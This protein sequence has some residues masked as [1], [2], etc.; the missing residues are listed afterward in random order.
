MEPTGQTQTLITQQSQSHPQGHVKDESIQQLQ[1]DTKI[2]GQKQVKH[3]IE[4]LKLILNTT[5]TQT[6]QV[7]LGREENNTIKVQ[8]QNEPQITVDMK[9]I[10]GQ[11]NAGTCS[12]KQHRIKAK[13]KK[14]NN[15]VKLSMSENKALSVQ[16]E[17]QPEKVADFS[18]TELNGQLAVKKLSDI[19]QSHLNQSAAIVEELVQTDSQNQLSGC[20]IKNYRKQAKVKREEKNWPDLVKTVK[21]DLTSHQEDKDFNEAT[22]ARIDETQHGFKTL[23]EGSEPLGVT[24]TPDNTTA[25]SKF[26]VESKIFGKAKVTSV[27]QNQVA[28]VP[29]V[30]TIVQT[31]G[32]AKEATS[33]FSPKSKQT[34]LAKAKSKISKA[35]RMPLEKSSPTALQKEEK[36]KNSEAKSEVKLLQN[37]TSIMETPA[38]QIENVAIISEKMKLPKSANINLDNQTKETAGKSQT[39]VLDSEKDS[40]VVPAA[41]EINPPQMIAG[42]ISLMETGTETCVALNTVKPNKEV[43]TKENIP[44]LCQ[45]VDATS[46]ASFDQQDSEEKLIG[47]AVDGIHL[48]FKEH[49]AHAQDISTVIENQKLIEDVPPVSKCVPEKIQ[50]E[51]IT[52]NRETEVCTE[53]KEKEPVRDVVRIQSIANDSQT[54]TTSEQCHEGNQIILRSKAIRTPETERRTFKPLE[55]ES[56]IVLEKEGHNNNP[57]IIDKCPAQMVPLE[58]ELTG[59]HEV[60]S[61][62]SL[63]QTKVKYC[64]ALGEI[65]QKINTAF[66][67]NYMKA[68]EASLTYGAFASP[69]NK[70]RATTKILEK[71]LNH[72]YRDEQMK[73]E[74]MLGATVMGGE[75]ESEPSIVT[76]AKAIS[77][78]SLSCEET[79]ALIDTEDFVVDTERQEANVEIQDTKQATS[80]STQRVISPLTTEAIPPSNI[81]DHESKAIASV[82]SGQQEVFTQPME[83]SSVWTNFQDKAGHQRASTEVQFSTPI[84]ADQVERTLS[85]VQDIQQNGQQKARKPIVVSTCDV[86][87]SQLSAELAS[88]W[89]TSGSINESEVT[90]GVEE[91][92]LTVT[93]QSNRIMSPIDESTLS[94]DML[95]LT[96]KSKVFMKS[97]I[98]RGS[99][100]PIEL[101]SAWT[102]TQEKAGHQTACSQVQYNTPISAELWDR[103][104]SPVQENKDALGN[105]IEFCQALSTVVQAVKAH[106]MGETETVCDESAFVSLDLPAPVKEKAIRS[107]CQ[108]MAEQVAGNESPVG[109]RMARALKGLDKE[110]SSFN[111]LIKTLALTGAECLEVI[112]MVESSDFV[113][114]PMAKTDPLVS[115]EG[116]QATMQIVSDRVFS[117][118]VLPSDTTDSLDKEEN[119]VSSNQEKIQTPF[120]M[121]TDEVLI[122]SYHR[123]SPDQIRS[124]KPDLSKEGS[125][126]LVAVKVRIEKLSMLITTKE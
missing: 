22:L 7:T 27:K 54:V 118:T 117:P 14:D 46:F 103:V 82:Q 78:A 119:A 125:Q 11:D 102:S 94:S 38:E 124:E 29:K 114:T 112:P 63:M 64:K 109:V 96:L 2:E 73:I 12:I 76:L 35:I 32:L 3:I 10:D 40:S 53:F 36:S 92:N 52:P 57:I 6:M 4:L 84:S 93:I 58:S 26:K 13:N 55:T 74:S 33:D 43:A 108:R 87:S 104:L 116:S 110:E 49:Q 48:N 67:T 105:K 9:H 44:V 25:L 95:P 1:K 8:Y 101:S 56:S 45:S 28:P 24:E 90:V 68:L 69:T 19:Q 70:Q 37:T 42:D 66:D 51:L 122:D 41:E 15:K 50:R 126:H 39:L 97:G 79:V 61:N 83:L 99:V 62:S 113:V 59:T 16:F 72:C 23:S 75:S 85:P 17:N 77:K 100:Q 115:I 106:R 107:I 65:Y 121:S 123:Y 31:T 98:E 47:K 80:I 71:V 60:C 21:S 81:V 120:G 18:K 30:E 89:K 111:A 88:I 91:N 34:L 86:K 5:T 20:S